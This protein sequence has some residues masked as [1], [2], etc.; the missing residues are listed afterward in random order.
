VEARG[1]SP[2]FWHTEPGSDSA[3]RGCNALYLDLG[4]R[5][6]LIRMRQELMWGTVSITWKYG[7]TEIQNQY[8]GFECALRLLRNTA[9]KLVANPRQHQH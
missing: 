1:D 5:R 6:G 7:R 3:C 2:L 9:S 8:A 4:C